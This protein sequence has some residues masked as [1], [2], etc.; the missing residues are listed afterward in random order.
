MD[1]AVASTGDLYVADTGHNRVRRID[2]R[3]GRISTVAGDGSASGGGDGGPAVKA[4][5]S[6][7]TGVSL[8]V[9]RKQVTLYIADA[10]VGRVR[11]VTP[12]GVITSLAL[13]NALKIGKPSRVAYH[14]RGFLYVA[15]PGADALAAVS[16]AP[17]V[18]V[19]RAPP[20][21]AVVQ[22][23]PRRAM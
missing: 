3:T 2:G 10:S 21:P 23:P 5:V 1:L 14:P 16:L 15:G 11:V 8:V 20:S 13:P 7:P 19:R 6:A 18:A 22:T 12:D 4:G 17:P 9:R